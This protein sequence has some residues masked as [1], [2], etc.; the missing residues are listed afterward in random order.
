M[1]IKANNAT[2]KEFN[3]PIG[4]LITVDNLY[5]MRVMELIKIDDVFIIKG[6]AVSMYGGVTADGKKILSNSEH[7]DFFTFNLFKHVIYY[8]DMDTF[9]FQDEGKTE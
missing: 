2:K 4:Q 3:I 8:H 9:E 6:T 7:K 1:D 5:H